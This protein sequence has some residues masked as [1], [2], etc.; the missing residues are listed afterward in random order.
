M[1][2][3]ADRKIG[4][5]RRPYEAPELRRVRLVPD[6]AVLASC[7]NTSTAGPLGGSQKCTGNPS[8]CFRDAS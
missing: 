1:K 3:D 7:K 2:P 4:A 6:E 5:G 8:L